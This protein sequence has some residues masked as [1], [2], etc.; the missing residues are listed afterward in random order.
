[1]SKG[2]GDT[3]G[4][5]G[6]FLG[7]WSRR[8]RAVADEPDAVVEAAPEAV[9][10][11]VEVAEKTD[12]EVMLEL[13]L[14]EPDTMRAGDDFSAFMARAVPRRLRDRALR[15]LWMS[16]PVLANLDGLVDY[17]DDYTDAATVVADMQ[18]AYKVGRGYLDE[19]KKFAGEPEAEVAEAEPVA[20]EGAD[21]GEDTD[22]AEADE[23]E[24]DEAFAAEN[25]AV[26][27]PEPEPP[28]RN[29]GHTGPEFTPRGRMR[30]RL[31]ED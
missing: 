7:R 6:D 12:A 11:P 17:A 5:A 31:V 27:G 8:K 22:E 29:S 19:A 28:V 23:A 10:G 9:S 21:T 16:D 3:G 14:P 13:G 15:R 20:A 4:E 30:F 18:T 1:L 25:N 26:D 2:G 24:A